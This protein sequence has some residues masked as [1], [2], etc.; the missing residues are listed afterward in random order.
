MTPNEKKKVEVLRQQGLSSGKIS[1]QL[2]LSTN[3]VKA[4]LRRH[5]NK[6]PVSR[7]GFCKQCGTAVMQTPHCRQKLFCSDACRMTWWNSH[8]DC[9]TRRGLVSAVCPECGDSFDSYEKEHRKYCSHGCYIKS[10]F[11]GDKSHDT[12]T[13]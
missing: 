6:Q 8:R 9:V 7:P 1:A 4:H 11:G 3:T 12:G 2:G 5:M 13:V 10:R